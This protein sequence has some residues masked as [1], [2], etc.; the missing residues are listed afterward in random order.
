M[1]AVQ[2]VAYDAELGI[3][4]EELCKVRT[5]Y[6]RFSRVSERTPKLET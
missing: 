4:S 3:G 2:L 5:N 6:R 1:M